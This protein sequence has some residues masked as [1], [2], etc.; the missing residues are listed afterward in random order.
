MF[1]IAGHCVNLSAVMLVMKGVNDL[2]RVSRAIEI[3]EERCMKILKGSR[4][5][6]VGEVSEFW[7]ESK[8]PWKSLK[9]ILIK[10]DEIPSAEVVFLMESYIPEGNQPHMYYW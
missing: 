6:A 3:P 1:S 10:C 8:K 7:L 2:S 9:E 5:E 4:E